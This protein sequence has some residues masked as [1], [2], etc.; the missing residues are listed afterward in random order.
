MEVVVQGRVTT[1][2]GSSKY[3]IVIESLEPAGIGALMA[4]LEERKR[5]LAAEG[6]FDEARKKPR[7]FLPRVVGI[8]TSPTGAVIRDMLHG[9]EERFPTR[10]IVWPVRVQGEG[11]AQEVAAAIARLQRARRRRSDRRAPTCI[12]VAR[13]GGSLEDLWGFN[14]EI[15]VR[16][17][18]G[19]PHSRHL[20]RR[21]RDRLDADRSRRRRPRADAHQGGGMGRAQIRRAHRQHRQSC[22]LRARHGRGVR[23]QSAR[24]HLK[25][26][27][28]GLP[29]PR[30]HRRAAAPA[31]RRL[32]APPGPRPARQH[33]RPPHAL[34]AHCVAAAAG[35]RAPA[36]VALPRAAVHLGDACRTCAARRDRWP[37]P[38]L[39]GLRQAHGLAQLPERPAARLRAGA[40][41]QR[42]HGAARAR[43]PLRRQPR[44]RVPRRPRRRRDAQRHPRGHIGAPPRRSRHATL[45]RKCGARASAAAGRVRFFN[46]VALQHVLDAARSIGNVS[47]PW[48]SDQSGS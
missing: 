7:P 47:F 39:R 1:F 35:D 20:R 36:R 48:G 37:S 41:R 31:L 22:G 27:A 9:F 8:V 38:S 43:P 11:S 32:R 10:V 34:C 42:P 13:G 12:I 2:P 25:A 17:V 18:A 23:W 46:L 16:A 45:P 30:R 5:K 44:A 3:Q 6:L 26:A 24:T 15:V 14:E 21:P 4:L 28:R 33:A 19:E 40:R 29:R